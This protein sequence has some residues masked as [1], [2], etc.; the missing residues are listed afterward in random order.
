Q[1]KVK[2]GADLAHLKPPHMN[3]PKEA[4]EQLLRLSG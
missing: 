3:A 4:L 1:E 2:E